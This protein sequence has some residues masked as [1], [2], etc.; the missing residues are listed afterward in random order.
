MIRGG[1]QWA[2]MSALTGKPIALELFG[3]VRSALQLLTIALI[4]A[5]GCPQSA[6]SSPTLS[7]MYHTGWTVREGAPRAIN[8]IAQTDGWFPVA[9]DG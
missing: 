1:L 7:Q 5:L 9:I 3:R 2:R 8:E 4:G 6:L